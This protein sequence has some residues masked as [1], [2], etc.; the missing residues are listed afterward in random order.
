MYT[1]F[2]TKQGEAAVKLAGHLLTMPVGARLPSISEYCALLGAGSGTVQAAIRALTEA[3]ALSVE[4]HGHR[5]TVVTGLNRVLLWRFNRGNRPVYGSMP[6]PNP[7]RYEGL[8]TGFYELFEKGEIPFSIT[9]L[10]GAR[11]RV[12]RLIEGHTDFVVCSRL[13]A[14][15]AGQ[16]EPSVRML[17]DLGKETYMTRTMM[18]FAEVG[19]DCI[20][21][22]MRVGIDY[23]CYDHPEINRVASEGKDVVFVPINYTNV[24]HKLLSREIDVTVCGLDE[25]EKEYPGMHCVPVTREG[26]MGRI[27]GEGGNAVIL[28]RRDDGALAGLLRDLLNPE[29][30]H[31]IQKDV[32]EGRKVPS[33]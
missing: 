28:I 18:V 25:S 17:M 16:V 1:E 19:H 8:A 21:D 20:E 24:Y 12:Q 23:S 10:R 33:Y 2:L 9:Y 32:M 29:A 11:L 6:L 26:R 3:G 27:T 7:T 13:S 30:L 15:L 31:S 4:A 14:E 5:G 22:G